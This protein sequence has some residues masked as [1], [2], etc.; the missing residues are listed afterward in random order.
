MKPSLRVKILILIGY[1]VLCTSLL[2][3]GEQPAEPVTPHVQ[4]GYDSSVQ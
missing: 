2:M 1:V 4:T 3:Q